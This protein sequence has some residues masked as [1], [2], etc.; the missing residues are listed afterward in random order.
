ME[1]CVYVL[2][3]CHTDIVHTQCIYTPTHSLSHVR[4][5]SVIVSEARAARANT[6]LHTQPF[7]AT[8]A[9]RKCVRALAL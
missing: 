7:F 9:Q 3:M 4:T 2:H 1:M 8:M 5:R 6:T